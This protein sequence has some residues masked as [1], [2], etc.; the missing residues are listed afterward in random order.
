MYTLINPIKK[1]SIERNNE[2]APL[3]KKLKRNLVIINEQR[4]VV[5]GK[6]NLFHMAGMVIK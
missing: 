1:Q 6:N 3:F 5:A 4:E 2:I